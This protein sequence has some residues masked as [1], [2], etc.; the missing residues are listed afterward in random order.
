[1][2]TLNLLDQPDPDFVLSDLQGLT[3][4][5]CIPTRDYLVQAI[6]ALLNGEQ[7]EPVLT[8]PYGSAIGHH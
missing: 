5:Q 2:D 4:R 7:P 1:M 3:F 8:Q 6:N